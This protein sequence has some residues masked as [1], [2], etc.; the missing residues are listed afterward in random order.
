MD[1]LDYPTPRWLKQVIKTF[2]AYL[3]CVC[4]MLYSA[5]GIWT[6][7]FFFFLGIQDLTGN[8]KMCT[9]KFMQKVVYGYMQ[10]S[11]SRQGFYRSSK[12]L[13]VAVYKS[14][15]ENLR[16]R[17]GLWLRPLKNPQ[18][19]DERWGLSCHMLV[20]QSLG[21]SAQGTV[22]GRWV[23]LEGTVILRFAFCGQG[24]FPEEL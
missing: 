4:T 5:R 10:M 18:D 9:I 15:G 17:N 23:W 2:T 13:G 20:F 1:N 14:A 22:L 21:R 11:G 16:G 24:E 8:H 19:P 3:Q 12:E 6:S 7:P